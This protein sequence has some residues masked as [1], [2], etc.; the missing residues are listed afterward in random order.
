MGAV[1]STAGLPTCRCEVKTRDS[2]IFSWLTSSLRVMYEWWGYNSGE[3]KMN[4]QGV[5]QSVEQLKDTG[6][7]PQQGEVRWQTGAASL[8]KVHTDCFSQRGG[9]QRGGTGVV[10]RA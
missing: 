10:H 4:W 9:L 2:P 8:W 5:P 6:V 1:V 7:Q 3:E